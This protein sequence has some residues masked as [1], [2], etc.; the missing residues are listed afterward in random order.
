MVLD[1]HFMLEQ[2]ATDL[3]IA[4]AISELGDS[5]KSITPYHSKMSHS[6]RAILGAAQSLSTVPLNQIRPDKSIDSLCSTPSLTRSPT[7]DGLDHTRPHSILKRRDLRDTV[8]K[9]DT[10]R[11]KS[12]QGSEEKAL[13]RLISQ[14]RQTRQTRSNSGTFR[15]WQLD[16]L[17][18]P[19][20][21]D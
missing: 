11:H 15:Y 3:R 16:L 18:W 8:H 20:C 4:G 14:T 12:M 9:K 17:G 1:S 5:T 7:P 19:H 10:R 21:L 13:R 2:A 6:R